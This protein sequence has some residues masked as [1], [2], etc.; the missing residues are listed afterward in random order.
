MDSQDIPTLIGFEPIFYK[1]RIISWAAIPSA[2]D[3]H[4]RIILIG[5]D[6]MCI[7][8]LLDL[9]HEEMVKFRDIESSMG[10]IRRDFGERP[11]DSYKTYE[12]FRS[13]DVETH[14]S[15]ANRDVYRPSF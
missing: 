9:P 7:D 12:Q 4:S 5:V 3:S 10:T 15:W 13:G 14:Y 6:R 2:D 11:I 1:K 8:T